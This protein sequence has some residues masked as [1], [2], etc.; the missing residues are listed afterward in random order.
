MATMPDYYRG[1]GGM[2]PFSVID[3]FG[4]DFYEGNVIKYVVRWRK[5]GGVGDLYKARRYVD[6]MIKR[7]EAEAAGQPEAAAPDPHI[8][9]VDRIEDMD[10]RP[11]VVGVDYDCLTI[12]AGEKTRVLPRVLAED[13]ARAI[14]S[15]CWEAA[16]CGGRM[17][18][19]L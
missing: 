19:E 13:L 4:L 15:A 18:A 12:W 3:A 7:A 1:K 10:G 16:D 6:E 5:K 17:A 2:S 14:N 9:K 8:R 11:L